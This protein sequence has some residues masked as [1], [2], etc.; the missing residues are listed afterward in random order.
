MNRQ[1]L[2]IFALSYFTISILIVIFFNGTGIEA[3]S[4]NH[5]LYAKYAPDHPELY[6]DHWAKPF[7]TLI[8][9][10][11]AQVGFVG[12]KIFNVICSFISALFMV[13]LCMKLN[14]KHAY[15][16][17]LF[18]FLFPLSFT[19]TFS[20]LTEPFCAA[21]L[22]ASIYLCSKKQFL[23]AAL[24]VSFLP[25]VR[26]EGLIFIGVFAIYFLTNRAWKSILFLSTGHLFF[27]ILGSFY[28]KDI[29]W[30]F[31]KI[32]YA[33][34]SSHYGSGSFFHFFEK[35]N[36]MMGLPLLVLFAIG[37]IVIFYRIICNSKEK[38]SLHALML[39]IFFSFFIAHS[40]FWYLGIFNSMGLKRVFAAITPI[41]AFVCL[42][43]FNSLEYIPS[44]TT[45]SV[46]QVVVVIIVLA[47]PFTS[48]PAAVEW[49]ELN[50]ST[51]QQNAEQVAD[52]LR[53]NQLDTARLLYTDPYL[54]EALDVD[55]FDPEQRLT[56]APE[57]LTMLAKGDVIIWDNWHAVIDYKVHQKDLSALDSITSFRLKK[58]LYIVYKK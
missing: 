39:I 29:L 15:L 3:D 54:S 23:I 20:G 43:G 58:S 28:Y 26:S 5:Y 25:F 18:L 31:N 51:A 56:L 27:S 34:L 6:L 45:R 30:V 11:F 46:S 21:I 48:N 12:I 47:F 36:Y 24:F 7:F 33:H 37:I 52:Y 50:L 35:L 14:H 41:M 10:T 53:K 32:P 42:L 57:A 49:E 9:S 1:S 19:T 17:A 8:A 16:S 38:M 22:M 40:L 55:P 2:F 4:I 13:K 44:R